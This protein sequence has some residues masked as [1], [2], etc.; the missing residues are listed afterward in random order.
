[1]ALDIINFFTDNANLEN[2]KRG[3]GDNGEVYI[4]EYVAGVSSELTGLLDLTTPAAATLTF[5]GLVL[6]DDELNSTV[7]NNLMLIDDNG[8]VSI[9][10]IADTLANAGDGQITFDSTAMV[11][12]EDFTTAPSLTTA[13]SY[14]AVLLGG[15]AG[16]DTY[17][18]WGNRFGFEDTLAI[19]Q[20]FIEKRALSG[21]KNKT[22]F[23]QKY[24]NGLMINGTTFTA[25]NSDTL[26][27]IQGM[28][29]YGSSSTKTGLARSIQ[30]GSDRYFR[31]AV[32]RNDTNSKGI[33][34]IL[35][36]VKLSADGDIN[37]R[38]A[39]GFAT[40]G[41]TMECFDLPILLKED[42]DIAAWLN[43]SED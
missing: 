23:Y 15:G 7:C 39:D 38:P 13:T 30:S 18:T 31:I 12:V 6:V 14:Q 27:A 19:A 28:K 11:L 26:K 29:S 21:A 24:G 22:V 17:S 40:Q 1:M 33:E 20:S 8:K 2:N 43:L 25:Q 5:S 36:L 41:F 9:G 3:V 4:A 37:L 16:T 10:K 42:E 34:D 32:V 35:W